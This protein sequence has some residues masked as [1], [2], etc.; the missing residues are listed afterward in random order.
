[1]Q[2]D[3]NAIGFSLIF[4]AAILGN[5][6]VALGGDATGATLNVNITQATQGRIGLALAFPANQK[7]AAGARQMAVVTF[8]ISASATFGTTTINFG[9]QPVLR[10]ASD[11]NANALPLS[12]TSGTI[13]ITK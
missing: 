5:P 3:E 9:D 1:S 7:F 6:V 2:G 11:V 13:T 8:T 12:F 4:D 10:E